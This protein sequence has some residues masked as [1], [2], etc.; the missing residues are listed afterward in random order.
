[1]KTPV[2]ILIG[3]HENNDWMLEYRRKKRDIYM[4]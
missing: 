1:M 2:L 3:T 4:Y